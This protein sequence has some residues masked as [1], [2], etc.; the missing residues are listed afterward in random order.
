MICHEMKWDYWTFLAQ[1][2]WFIVGMRAK[3]N[4]DV[5]YQNVQNKKAERQMKSS[6]R[7]K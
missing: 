3:I 4:A 7:R 1:P 2:N 6:G 5:T